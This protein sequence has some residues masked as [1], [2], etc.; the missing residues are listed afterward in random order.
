MTYYN[1]I[2][3]QHRWRLRPKKL[4][5]KNHIWTSIG[6]YEIKGLAFSTINPNCIYIQ[7]VDYELTL[8]LFQDM[9]Q[10]ETNPSCTDLAFEK[11]ISDG[12]DV[13]DCPV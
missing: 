7:G 5:G 6:G 10:V 11:A 2:S 8:W 3:S 4:T 12:V 9:E 13:L 1:F